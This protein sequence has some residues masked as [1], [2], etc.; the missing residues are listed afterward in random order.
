MCGK[1]QSNLSFVFDL[2]NY[3]LSSILNEDDVGELTIDRLRETKEL[4]QTI[5][6]KMPN[7]LGLHPTIYFYSRKG[8]FRVSVFYAVLMFVK[9]IKSADRLNEFTS[10]RGKFETFIYKYDYV[11]DQINRSQRT[12]K[13]SVTVLTNFY[14]GVMEYLRDGNDVDETMG[15]I[16]SS[17]SYPK[18]L[19]AKDEEH[20]SNTDFNA[21]RKSEVFIKQAFSSALKCPICGGM[22]HI[23]SISIDYKVRK[24]GGGNGDVL[25]GQTTHFY[26]NTTYKN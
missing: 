8:N 14:M 7:S 22:L 20:I 15:K 1:N 23:N 3:S 21:N 9:H 18:F 12:I 13:K 5:S 4:L 11:I 2:G 10:V 25:N 6:S 17:N 26:C 19:F 16:L 24:E